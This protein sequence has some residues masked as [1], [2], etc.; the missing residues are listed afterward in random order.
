MLLT[1]Y[2][3]SSPTA[4]YDSLEKSLN[5]SAAKNIVLLGDFN[6]KHQEWFNGDITNSQG[7][8]LNDLSDRFDMSQIWPDQHTWTEMEYQRAF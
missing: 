4:F 3:P 6:A 7:I 8:A 5:M 1:L 2:A